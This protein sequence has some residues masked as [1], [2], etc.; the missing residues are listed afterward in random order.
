MKLVRSSS[1]LQLFRL[2]CQT[3]AFNFYSEVFMSLPDILF[4]T[5]GLL[6]LAMTAASICRHLPIPYTV[7]LV[8][9]G[10]LVNYFADDIDILKLHDFK[11]VQLTPDLVIFIFL[12]ALVFESAL[13]LDARALLKNIVPILM[14]AI[15]GMLIS[16]AL[17]GVG[18][19]WS[20]GL[21]IVI[22]LL[23]GSLISATDPVAVVA[24][25]KELGVSRRLN[26]LVEGE[27]LMNDAT[28][29]VLFN[30]LLLMLTAS[31]F[32]FTDGMQA[33]ERFCIVFLGGILVGMV[34]SIAISELLVRLYHGNESIP[35]VLSLAIAYT[36]F[37]AAE[38]E[39]HVSGVM[40]VLSAAIC[41]NIFGLS[42]MSK[43]TIENIHTT[44]EFV[45][46]IFNSLLFVL[47]GLSVDLMELASY[48]QP[49]LWAVLA[50]YVARAVG[51]YFLV[52][53]TTRLFALEKIGL[54]EQHIMWWGG[55]KGGLAIAIVLSVPDSLPEKKL[56]V[57][58]TLGV[59][60]VSLLLNASTIRS[61]M[62]FLKM[63]LLV[64]HEQGELKQGM[65]RVYQSVD[66][67]LQGF[68]QLNLLEPKLEAQ[69][70]FKL[71]QTLGAD[72]ISL[73][74]EQLMRQAHLHA[75]RAEAQEIEHLYD[76]GLV[77]YYTLVTFKD[78]LRV[79]QQHSGDYLKNTGVG[80]V[81]PTYVLDVEKM[82]I[83]VLSRSYWTQGLLLR[84]Q[85]SRFANKILHDIAGIL[86]AHK[87][88][89][90]IEKMV[91]EGFNEQLVAPLKAIYEQRL[92]RR[93]DRL[94]YFSTNY[95]LFYQQYEAFIFHKV[96]L[97]FALK[98]VHQSH[99]DGIISAKV[100]ALIS[101]KLASSLKELDSFKISLHTGE[102]Q[103]WITKVPLF[104]DLPV[105]FLKSM[106]SRATYVNFLPNDVIFDQGNNSNSLYIITSGI[107]EIFTTNE[108]GSEQISK[109]S[110]G[111][112]ISKYTLSHVITFKVVA[113]TFVTCLCLTEHDIF[114]FSFEN[115]DFS[116][117]LQQ[118]KN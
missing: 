89:E 61:L 54:A 84:Y 105:D 45:V 13:S 72:E 49:V 2:H 17:V 23:F 28:A 26:I 96:A 117:R 69:V 83:R 104:Q 76:I 88:L 48:W 63:D 27:S 16:V 37:I 36:S 51:V 98:L 93:Q 112:L 114:Q 43:R 95:P 1:K 115:S 22:A 24:L 58:L 4:I 30:I 66:K 68:T 9:L 3:V 44:W 40:A 91:A 100:L 39:L 94:L 53:V 14:L 20:L 47:I 71:H 42:R 73:S 101:K 92:Q 86:M 8:I 113:K 52:P 41:L 97:R 87:S 5:S 55:L 78:I 18:I 81:Q 82:I 57:V 46:L 116:Q 64:K 106:A 85:T 80:W 118:L 10:L 6:V 11:N 12:P 35:V 102:R 109:L 75:I 99:E 103:D 70:A 32:S 77:N 19:W 62:H 110:E 56:L 90:A 25:F 108:S 65:Q 59:V 50:V 111:E 107:A 74:D 29:I 31:H 7:L 79:D 15:V 33:V 60:L 34:I 21:P 67:V 38:H